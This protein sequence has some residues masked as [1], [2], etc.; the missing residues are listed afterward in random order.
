MD[1]L[2]VDTNVLFSFFKADSTT[3]KLIRKLRGILDL[4]TPE[5]AYDELQKYKSEIIK[6]SKISPERF[7]EILGILSHIV[8]PIPE[9]EYADKIQEAVEI[10][11]DLGDI[12]FVALALKLNC[13]IWSNDK[14]LKNLKNVQ[15]LDTKEVVDLLQD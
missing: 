6:K 7:E 13:P 1:S 5:Y 10:T 8:I 11:P 9:S 15:V 12:D 14:K 3:R 4:Y 2:V